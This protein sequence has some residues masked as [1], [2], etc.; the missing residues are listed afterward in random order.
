[1]NCRTCGTEL[2][3]HNAT[4]FRH[5]HDVGNCAQVLL[6]QRDAAR[7]ELAKLRARLDGAMEFQFFGVGGRRGDY[8]IVGFN[9]E[10]GD[11]PWELQVFTCEERSMFGDAVTAYATQGEATDEAIRLA[12]TLTSPSALG[13]LPER[14]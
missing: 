9:D 5:V 1:M 10:A 12:A 7:D 3:E 4:S 13:G 2:T 14:G 6:A 11:R 8:V